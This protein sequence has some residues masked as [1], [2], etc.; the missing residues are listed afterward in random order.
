MSGFEG[1]SVMVYVSVMILFLVSNVL[2]I[3]EERLFLLG[4]KEGCSTSHY[5]NRALVWCMQAVAHEVMQR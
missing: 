3:G 4:G 2:Q 1:I 5:N